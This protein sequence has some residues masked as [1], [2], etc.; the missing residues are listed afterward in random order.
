[1]PAK[2]SA[3][4]VGFGDEPGL[5]RCL[6]AVLAALGADDELLLVD[7]GFVGGAARAL[8]VS[9]RIRV[10]GSGTNLG[11]TG[12]CNLASRHARGDVI[13]LV[14]SD[15][16][17]RPGSLAVLADVA[18]R[19]GVGIASGCLRLAADPDLVNTVGNPVH[20]LGISWAGACGE[21]AADFAVEEDLASATGGFM[22]IR[23]T[24]WNELGGFRDV[25]F[26][27]LEDTELSLR[28][29]L[30]GLRVVFV[31]EAVALHDY[32][33]GRH[34]EKMYLLER[35]RFLLL[36]TVFPGRVLRAALPMILVT[37][38]LFLALA[39]LQGWAGQKLRAW[40]WLLAH[41]AELRDLRAAVQ[42]ERV[43]AD[44]TFAALLATRIEPPMVTAPP[45]MSLA[46]TVL[47]RYW[48]RRW[49]PAGLS[50]RARR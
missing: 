37:E 27:Y 41:R 32:E 11:F 24:L 42:G 48:R 29:H 22:A 50:P 34:P 1:M 15:A 19:P 30:R 25:Y 14:N 17:V 18:V 2:L 46:N 10:L 35:N 3:V 7:N 20:Y 36:A 16:Y 43:I 12:G 13:V 38:P 28:C 4:V 6:N 39:V 21:P 23:R 49:A 5:E 26:A 44:E 40:W 47:D 9:D 33:F 31:P 8:A 45:G